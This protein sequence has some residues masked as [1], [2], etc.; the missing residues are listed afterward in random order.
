MRRVPVGIPMIVTV[1]LALPALAADPSSSFRV[2][3]G[4]LGPTGDYQYAVPQPTPGVAELRL[5]VGANAAFEYRLGQRL[6][7]E[8]ALHYYE[9]DVALSVAGVSA[10]GSVR[11]L[12]ATL[13]LLFHADVGDAADFSVGAEVAWVSYGTSTLSLL[14]QDVLRVTPKSEWTWGLKAG[15]DGPLGRNWTVGARIEYIAARAKTDDPT[16]P[17]LDPC[18]ILF[19]VGVARRF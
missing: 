8:A 11:V 16:L 13:G 9:P 19:N 6:G 7:V 17:R 1:F 5:G 4:I 14:G 3:L 18:P 2:G 15:L 10:T 12:P